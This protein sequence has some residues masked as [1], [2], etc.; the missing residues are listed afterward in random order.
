MDSTY[1]FYFGV[2][3][4]WLL[5]RGAKRKEKPAE[6]AEERKVITFGE[7]PEGYW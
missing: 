1:Y 6:T 7:L 2:V 5:S 3:H 4:Q